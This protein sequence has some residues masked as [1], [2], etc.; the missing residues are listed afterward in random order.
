MIAQFSSL[1]LIDRTLFGATT[2]GKGGPGNNG[3]EGVLRIYQE[4]QDYWSLNL[5]LYSVTSRTFVGRELIPPLRYSWYI[6]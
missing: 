5:R 3:N 2:P 4:I 6:L 1:W